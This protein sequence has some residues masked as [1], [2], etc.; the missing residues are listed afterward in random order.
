MGIDSVETSR[1][2]VPVRGPCFM[3]MEIL[4][5]IWK[6]PLSIRCS[7]LRVE[8]KANT[9]LLCEKTQKR[10]TSYILK[11]SESSFFFIF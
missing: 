5:R 3:L 4:V 2:D 1:R 7:I 8:D 9:E 6:R 11:M 10:K